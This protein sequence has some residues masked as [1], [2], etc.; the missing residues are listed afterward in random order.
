MTMREE[1]D[2][3]YFDGDTESTRFTTGYTTTGNYYYFFFHYY[4]Y[5]LSHKLA[6]TE[7][8]N[9]N[10]QASGNSSCEMAESRGCQA[11]CWTHLC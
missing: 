4:Y 11:D 1:I 3:Y 10:S 6:T 5:S 8:L 9:L 2:N 7:E